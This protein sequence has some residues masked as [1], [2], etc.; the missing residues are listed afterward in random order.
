V[1]DVVAQHAHGLI[2]F[3]Q[4][5]SDLGAGDR[6]A[7][8]LEEARAIAERLAANPVL[9]RIDSC[10]AELVQPSSSSG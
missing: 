5:L 7:P 8:L 2:D 3:A 4:R 10:A 6:A 9:A 1:I